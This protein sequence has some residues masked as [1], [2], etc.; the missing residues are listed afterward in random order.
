MKANP[1]PNPEPAA[2]PVLAVVIPVFNEEHNIDALIGDWRP[3]FEKT[4]QPFRI[5]LVDDGSRDQSLTILNAMQEKDPALYVHSQPN[6]GHG[7]AI[8]KGYSMAV[9]AEW[10]FQV[11]SDHQ[12]ETTAFAELWANRDR[13]D[14]LV[15]E[16]KEK[17]ASRPRQC[18]SWISKKI[19]HLLV[20][21]GVKDVNSPYRLMRAEKIRDALKKIQKDSFAPNI[22]LTAWFIHK[23]YRIFTTVTAIR[24]TG[25]P[26]PSKMNLYFLSGSLRSAFQ[27]IFFRIRL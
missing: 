19:V 21:T 16:R 20:G 2:P 14:L 3:I 15:A 5:I 9:D 7:P 4:G 22:L 17:N 1:G 8:L 25:I 27:T 13:Y 24:R 11:D 18:I 23:K 12:L 6:A 26:R 10:I